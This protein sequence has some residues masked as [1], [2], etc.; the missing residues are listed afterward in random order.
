MSGDA[1]VGTDD[2]CAQE[3][4]HRYIVTIRSSISA[5]LFSD[6]IVVRAKCTTTAGGVS[7]L[8]TS[9]ATTMARVYR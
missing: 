4:R 6:S 5:A 2:D 7:D 1:D 3:R 8:R 9:E